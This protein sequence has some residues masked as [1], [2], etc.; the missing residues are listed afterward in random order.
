MFFDDSVT[1]VANQTKASI[2]N[3]KVSCQGSSDTVTKTGVKRKSFFILCF[4]STQFFLLCLIY[5]WWPIL[6]IHVGIGIVET[7]KE[8]KVFKRGK[9]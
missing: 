5:T 3:E 4:K 6:V 2:F 1:P 8:R 9:F 7:I